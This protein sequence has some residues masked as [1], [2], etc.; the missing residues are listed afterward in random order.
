MQALFCCPPS[1][2]DDSSHASI[3][4]NN[5]PIAL[6]HISF[7]TDILV[8]HVV[9]F[10]HAFQT[11]LVVP[12]G[13]IAR[14]EKYQLRKSAKV[15]NVCIGKRSS[16]HAYRQ[17]KYAFHHGDGSRV[18]RGPPLISSELPMFPPE[19]DRTARRQERRL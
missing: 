10:A 3:K 18:T 13:G 9:I 11:Y 16:R 8:L 6:N 4:S 7:I 14:H 2:H 15:D 19:P 12:Y 17:N 1:S 5:V